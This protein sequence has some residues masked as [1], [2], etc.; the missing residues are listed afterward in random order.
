MSLVVVK[1][2]TIIIKTTAKPII[3]WLTHYNKL[4][5]KESTKKEIEFIKKKLYV[6]GQNYNFYLTKFNRIILRLNTKDPIKMLSEEKAIEKGVEFLSELILYSIIITIPILEIRKAAIQ[7]K[8]EKLIE[9][10]IV[11]RI[12]NAYIAIKEENKEINDLLNKDLSL[13][14]KEISTLI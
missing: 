13:K 2:I 7:K 8:K 9:D 6:V 12:S 3:S 10:K 11:M 1:I 4:I 14:L 5:L